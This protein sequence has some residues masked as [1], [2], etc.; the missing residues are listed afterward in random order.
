[1]TATLPRMLDIGDIKTKSQDILFLFFSFYLFIY[2]FRRFVGNLPCI[3]R[4]TVS[5]IYAAEEQSVF[6][7]FTFGAHTEAH[8]IL[9]RINLSVINVFQ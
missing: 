4:R 2:F 6:L 3:T 8:Q 7:A 9:Q 5:D 1:M